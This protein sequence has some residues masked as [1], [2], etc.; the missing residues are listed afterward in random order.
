[1]RRWFSQGRIATYSETHLGIKC[2]SHLNHLLQCCSN[3]RAL[4]QGRQVHQQIAL[5]GLSLSLFMATKMI[6]MYAEC[7]DLFSARVLFDE[8]PHKNV[9]AW[10]AIFTFYSRN[11]LYEECLNGYGEMRLQGVGPDAYVFPKV[12]R[13]CAQAM[14]LEEGICIHK[15]VIR[16]G[17]ESIPQVCNSLID[18]YSKCGNVGSARWVFDEM[19]GRDL[20]SWNSMISGCVSNGFLDSA[21]RLLGL[22]RSDGL[23]P[24]VVSWNIVIDAYCRKGLC[25]EASKMFEQIEEPNIISWTTLISGYSRV[26]KHEVSLRIFTDMMTRGGLIPDPDALSSVLGSCRVLGACKSGREIHGYGIKNLKRFEFYDSAGAALLTLYGSFGRM[27]YARLVF[28]LMDITDVVTWNAI[29]LSLAHRGTG[30]SALR[31][32]GE[33]Q[34]RGIENDENTLSTI[35]PVCNL[36]FGK[37]IHAYIRKRTFNS[38][39][40]VSNALINMYS[41]CGCIGAAYKVFS[42]MEIRDLVSWNSMMGGCSMYGD[43]KA[44][45]GLLQ[46]MNRSSIQPNSVTFTSAL[47]ACSHSGLVDEGLELFN[48][49]TEQFSIV[50]TMEQFACVVDLLARAGRLEDAIKFINNTSVIPDKNIWGALLA[51]SRA[52]QNIDVGKQAAE[53]LF[54]LEPQ[55]PGNYITLSNIYARAG[56]WDDAVGTRKLMEARGLAKLS[57]HSWIEMGTVRDEQYCEVC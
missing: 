19:V 46:E 35:L 34:S 30:D 15:D 52:Y 23:E 10:T 54:S 22:V 2:A 29:I 31:C 3:S 41:K 9:F 38:A 43:G 37:Q 55:N 42:N 49:L 27:Q 53:H 18:M 39:V 6:Q 48:R 44:A 25:E 28:E 33:M 50:P 57:G 32:F 56:K 17:A 24:D 12:L 11:G 13:A 26:G 45:L 5:R 7:N 51:A 4:K 21:V 20:L 8:L 40:P 14:Y 36:K 47:S 16:F 1:M